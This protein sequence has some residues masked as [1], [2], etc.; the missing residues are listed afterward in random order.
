[1][2]LLADAIVN[3]RA[4]VIKLCHA[5]VAY[6]AVLAPKRPSDPASVTEKFAIQLSLLT[7]LPDDLSPG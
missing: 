2:V 7:K 5:P 1:M 4:V 3:P 6:P